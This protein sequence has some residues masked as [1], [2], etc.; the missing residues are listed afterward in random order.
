MDWTVPAQDAYIKIVIPG[1]LQ[2]DCL[3]AKSFKEVTEIKWD[4]AS[5]R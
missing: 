2:C 3:G 4:H 5:G 1:A